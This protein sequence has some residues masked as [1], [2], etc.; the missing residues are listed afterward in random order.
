[1]PM[2]SRVNKEQEMSVMVSALTHVI[3]G[4]HAAVEIGGGG[5]GRGRPSIS[6][7]KRGREKESSSDYTDDDQFSPFCRSYPIRSSNATVLSATPSTKFKSTITTVTSTAAATYEYEHHHNKISTNEHKSS[8]PTIRKYRGVRQRPWGKWAAEIRDPYKATRVWLGTFD[9]AEDAAQAYDEA[10]LQF[11]GSKAKLNFPENV[12][13]IQQP[14]QNQKNLYS[15]QVFAVSNYSEPVV[16]SQP[17]FESSSSRFSSGMVIPGD[18][19]QGHDSTGSSWGYSSELP[20][21]PVF[22][23]SVAEP[24]LDVKR[25]TERSR[26][27]GGGHPSSCNHVEDKKF[28]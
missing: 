14:D 6:A 23:T 7:Y 4:D 8:K 5:S 13:L 19:I 21:C 25:G 12:R 27:S 2:A 26:S 15:K 10:A 3:A 24:P 11:R 1:M 9:T 17:Q 16:Y 20:H 22:Y 28:S 18:D